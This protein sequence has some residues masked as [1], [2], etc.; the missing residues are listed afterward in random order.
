MKLT[1]FWILRF[2]LA[3][4]ALAGW[5]PDAG[6]AA[7]RSAIALAASSITKEELTTHVDTL[8]DDTFEGREAGS[9]GGRAAG[10]YLLKALEAHGLKPAGDSATFFQSF[11]GS[12]RNVLAMLEGSDPELKK[13][14]VQIGAHYDHVGY[15]RPTNSFGP[16]GYIH[17][18]ADDNASGVAGLLEVIDAVK[19]LPEP[20][21]RSILFCFW[22]SEESGLIGSR[23]WLSRPT[24]PLDRVV[25]SI[26]LDMIGRMK[27]NYL[28]VCGTR[29]G[30]GLRRLISESIPETPAVM[31]FTWKMKA[32]SDHWPFYERRIPVVMFHTGLHNDYHRPSDDAD[33]INHEGLRTAAQ[34][35]L[36]TLLSVADADHLPT[37][38]QQALRESVAI[39][40]QLEQPVPA[41]AVRYGFP[42]KADNEEGQP[43]RLVL[44]GVNPGSPA[45]KAGFKAG[46]RLI[47]FQ[48]QPIE[49]VQR[50]RLQLLAATGETTI[51]VER[52]GEAEPVEI[53]VTP[54]G[55]PVRIGITWRM[56]EG[57]PG[58]ALI[59]Q[60]TF[61]SAAQ[62]AGLK[63]KDRIY[64]VAGHAFTTQDEFSRLLRETPSP[65]ELLIE[66]SG[67][68]QTV[69][70]EVLD[71]GLP[72]AE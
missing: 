68:V 22:D 47:S 42:F 19:K 21:R 72:A 71:D 23:H 33:R 15:G 54:L 2:A 43:L 29:T 52:E 13:Q 26:N 70:L 60:V 31:D 65:I 45:E 9:R 57:E 10:N 53:K 35:A 51:A 55:N 20:P 27:D 44:T 3:G 69:Q 7:D 40:Q 62:A 50:F 63:L 4:V 25:F 14:V 56:D 67:K 37:F 64:S 12:C 17:N 39:Q 58:T 11:N 38:R 5:L 16:F 18:G 61:G 30:T 46:D 36:Y 8:A 66:R 32:D 34:V 1:H 49:N 24:I 28:E 48:G 41:N 59:T 6:H